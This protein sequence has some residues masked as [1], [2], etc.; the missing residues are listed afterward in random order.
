MQETADFEAFRV[1]GV[2]AMTCWISREV[3]ENLKKTPTDKGDY[4]F[5]VEGLGR[6]RFRFL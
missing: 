1:E 2:E 4:L 5:H 6:Y 3:L